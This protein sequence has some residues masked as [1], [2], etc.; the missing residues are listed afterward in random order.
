MPDQRFKWLCELYKPVSKVTA[1]I[2]LSCSIIIPNWS[3][4]L[5]TFLCFLA[6]LR[7]SPLSAYVFS[8]PYST[9]SSLLPNFPLFVYLLLAPSFFAG[10]SSALGDGHCRSDQGRCWRR[11]SGKRLLEPH[12]RGNI[13]G[14]AQLF[15]KII[16]LRTFCAIYWKWSSSFCLCLP[17]IALL[18]SLSLWCIFGPFFPTVRSKT[19]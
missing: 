4:L 8:T 16:L 14:T 11:W 10:A 1:P 15:L 12:C 17:S 19:Q 6:Y 5:A 18:R 2:S 9:S 13:F 7:F 3:L